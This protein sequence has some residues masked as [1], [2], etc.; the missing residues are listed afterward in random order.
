VA[1]PALVA[2]GCAV[3]RPTL[4]EGAWIA[5]DL[6]VHSSV[7]SN[8]TDGLGTVDALGPAMEVAG[9]DALWL[10][11]HSN[12]AGSMHCADVEDCPNLG[13]ETTP[14]DWPPGVYAGSEISPIASLDG[15]SLDPVGHVGCLALDGQSLGD[16]PFV[17]RPPGQVTGGDAL[18]QCRDAAGFAVVNHPYAAASW[19]AYDWTSE[20]FDG[21]EVYNGGTR[22][23]PWDAETV[24]AWE[25]RVVDRD[26]VPVGGSD[27]HRWGT[28]APGTLLD[29]AL[30]W[31]L[32][33]L[34][35]DDAPIE[36][37]VAGRVVVAEPGTSLHIEAWNAEEAVGVG[38]GLTG[39]ATVRAEATA[40]EGGLV[41]QLKRADGEVLAEARVDG[42]TSVEVEVEQGAVY[43][44]VWPEGEIVASTGG[45]GLTNVIR[46]GR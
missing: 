8:D 2:L 10:T 34:A 42:E 41:L 45:V 9:L 17:D 4:E 26:V 13:P 19:V 6:H 43:A 27:S 36:A 32:T 33:W 11:D 22:F 23:D 20:A 21:L 18:D 44:R 28:E 29:P 37:L 15:S 5:T 12:S 3:T 7:G 16:D 38:G 14:G 31:P 40:G 24:A 30:G 46:V 25:A 35:V 39:P 1:A